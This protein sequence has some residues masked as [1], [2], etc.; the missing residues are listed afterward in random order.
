MTFEHEEELTCEQ[1]NSILKQ[2]KKELQEALRKE[3]EFKTASEFSKQAQ[4]LDIWIPAI[5]ALNLFMS[6]NEARRWA[7]D[8]NDPWRKLLFDID[9]YGR[10]KSAKLEDVA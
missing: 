5:D 6:I 4:K 8:H 3:I 7:I 2:E 9:E 1:E 10:V